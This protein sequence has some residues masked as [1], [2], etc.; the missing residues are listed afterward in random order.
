MP[1]TLAFLL[2]NRGTHGNP[3]F[4]KPGV[5]V[6]VVTHPEIAAACFSKWSS[7]L[8]LQTKARCRDGL[9]QRLTLAWLLQIRARRCAGQLAPL[10]NVLANAFLGG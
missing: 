1:R 8:F 9:H 10:N 7:F 2:R 3:V 6:L 4:S 5:Q